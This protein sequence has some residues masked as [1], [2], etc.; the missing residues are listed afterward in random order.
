M[1]IRIRIVLQ[2]RHFMFEEPERPMLGFK[3]T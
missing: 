1:E 3:K 2:K